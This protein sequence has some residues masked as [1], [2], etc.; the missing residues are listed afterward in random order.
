MTTSQRNHQESFRTLRDFQRAYYPLA[1]GAHE[2]V[3]ARP[4]SETL[5]EVILHALS[6][7]RHAA[8]DEHASQSVTPERYR[9]AEDET[10]HAL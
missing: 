8:A 6:S 7:D 2:P 9:A 4:L 3:P 1:E 10:S 5:T